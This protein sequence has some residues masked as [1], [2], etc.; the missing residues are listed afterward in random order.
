MV[1]SNFLEWY[2]TMIDCYY[3]G[4]ILSIFGTKTPKAEEGGRLSQQQ[5]KSGEEISKP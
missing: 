4:A 2:C 1:F 3:H 5:E